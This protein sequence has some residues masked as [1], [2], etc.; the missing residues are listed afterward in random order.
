MKHSWL[1]ECGAVTL[2]VIDIRAS[3]WTTGD[4]APELTGLKW[5]RALTFKFASRLEH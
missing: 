4:E 5:Q 1:G 3:L 2:S